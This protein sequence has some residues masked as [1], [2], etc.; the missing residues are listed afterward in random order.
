MGAPEDVASAVAFLCSPGAR[1]I[2]GQTIVVDG[3]LGLTSAPFEQ[4][5]RGEA[6]A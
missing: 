5:R 3:G 6:R 4:F 1:Y 2:A